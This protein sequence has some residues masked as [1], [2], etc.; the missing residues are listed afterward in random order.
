MNNSLI[1]Q[2]DKIL[3]T[4]V[5]QIFPAEE[6]ENRTKAR[7]AIFNLIVEAKTTELYGIYVV[8]GVAYTD[9]G[10]NGKT[11]VSDR[12]SQLRKGR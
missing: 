7:E 2:V 1:D 4:A 8:N 6:N 10:R 11:L 3:D 5:F 12:I 9:M